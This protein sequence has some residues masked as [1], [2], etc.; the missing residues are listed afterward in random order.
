VPLEKIPRLK[1]PVKPDWNAPETIKPDISSHYTSEKAIGKLFRAIDLPALQVQRRSARHQY[2]QFVESDTGPAEIEVDEA[3]HDALSRLVP[4]YI[5]LVEEDVGGVSH[6]FDRFSSDLFDI[7]ANHAL[8]NSRT[9]VLTEEEAIV[10]TIIAKTS[11]PRRRKELM[12]KLREQT[13]HLV[14]GIREQLAG[15][16]DSTQ[17]QRLNRAWFAWE[18]SI[19]ER[20]HKRFGAHSFGWIALGA[21]FEAIKDLEGEGRLGHL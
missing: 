2:R 15:D 17:E 8:S 3:I 1:F 20:K 4:R 21:I 12:S 18:L 19:A 5:S 13:D 14:R 9:A 11:Q 16:E 6:T 10:G 7:C